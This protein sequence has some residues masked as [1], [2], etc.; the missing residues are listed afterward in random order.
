[1]QLKVT[2]LLMSQN[3]HRP[4]VNTLS[5]TLG[6]GKAPLATQRMSTAFSPVAAARWWAPWRHGG[7]RSHR[8]ERRTCWRNLG[9]QTQAM[10]KNSFVSMRPDEHDGDSLIFRINRPCLH[11]ST[12]T[13]PA[14][15]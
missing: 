8:R 12:V 7:T 14:A 4:H 13:S 5:D 6:K 10:R 15:T 11:I 3:H 9:S 2:E 1:M